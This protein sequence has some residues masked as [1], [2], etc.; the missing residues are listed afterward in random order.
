LFIFLVTWFASLGSPALAVFWAVNEQYVAVVALLAATLIAYLPWDK[1]YLSGVLSRYARQNTM[2]YCKCRVV[3]QSEG[4]MPRAHDRK[5]PR[6]RPLLYAVHPHGAFCMGWSVLFCSRIMNE[7]G[8]RFCFSPVLH[9]SPLFRLWSRLVGRPGSAAKAA[10][11]GYMKGTKEAPGE[12]VAL[13]PGG[14][15]EATLTCPGKDRVFIKKRVGFIKLALQYGY[16]VA[17]VYSFGE[18]ET[19]WNAQGL[20]KLRLWLNSLGLPAI[21]VFGSWLC[22]LMPK[23]QPRGLAV[24]VGEP[25]ILPT[26]T[27]PTREEVKLWHDKYMAA[28]VRLFE[29]HKEDYYGPHASK[30]AKLELW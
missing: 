4:S 22:P 21:A 26:I 5:M 18:N 8:V 24:V 14:F 16:D 20:W 17:P 27:A 10:M 30:T 29:E 13:P 19:F 7:G 23:R 1:G 15:E 9:A 6:R 2:Y 12:H 25:L 11:V 3:Y 28:L